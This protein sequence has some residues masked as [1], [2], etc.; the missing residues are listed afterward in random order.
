VKDLLLIDGY[1]IIH[2]WSEL[3]ELL[4]TF[5]YEAAR[6]RLIDIICDF[7]AQKNYD[8]VI[9][10]DAHLKKGSIHS[11]E[12]YPPIKVVYTGENITADQYIE[13][14]VSQQDIRLRN[15]YVATSD[16]LEQ[17]IVF[18]KGGARLSSRELLRMV[19]EGKKTQRE[20]IEKTSGKNTIASTL[21]ED[22]LRRLD[23][24][25]KGIRLEE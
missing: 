13:R 10:F 23:K 19:N 20:T 5:N 21:N 25:I 4:T 1:N 6:T 18:G 22:T 11:E 8:T 15:V 16:A 7:S 3:K 17:T 9:V 24:I 12:S 14:M 2:S